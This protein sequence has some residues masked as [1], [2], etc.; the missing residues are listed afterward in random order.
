MSAVRSEVEELRDKISKLEVRLFFKIYIG[1]FPPFHFQC[2]QLAD[3]SDAQ[4]KK[5]RI[6][7]RAAEQS[8]SRIFVDF[9]QKGQ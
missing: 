7:S 2:C 1:P 5:R 9:V 8:C 3:C 4:L 6:K